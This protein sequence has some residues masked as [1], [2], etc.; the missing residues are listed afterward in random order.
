MHDSVVF[1]LAVWYALWH[2]YCALSAGN[3]TPRRCCCV[4]VVDEWN[5]GTFEILPSD[6]DIHT[7]NERRLSEIVGAVA[8]KLHTGRRFVTRAPCVAHIA[9]E[10]R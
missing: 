4:Q 8:G 7:A 5:N 6:E 2:A 10:C 3:L 9:V 1:I